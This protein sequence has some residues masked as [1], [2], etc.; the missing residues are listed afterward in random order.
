MGRTIQELFLHAPFVHLRT[1][2]T[3]KMLSETIKQGVG[4]LFIGLLIVFD[5]L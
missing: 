3:D 5:R 2:F 4:I 1:N